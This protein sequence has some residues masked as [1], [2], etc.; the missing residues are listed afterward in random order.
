[1]LLFVLACAICT[2]VCVFMTCVVY[3]CVECKGK[4]PLSYPWWQ[5]AASSASETY[6][7]SVYFA[8]HKNECY[9]AARTHLDNQS[10]PK[11]TKNSDIQK[12][13]IDIGEPASSS[14]S[15]SSSMQG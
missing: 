5:A 9:A 15:S 13:Y 4:G 7:A 6:G 11:P 10:Y 2:Y 1:M 12:Y 8:S 3:L 14:S